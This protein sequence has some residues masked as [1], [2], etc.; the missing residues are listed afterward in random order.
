MFPRLANETN[1]AG[2]MEL[3]LASLVHHSDYFLDNLPINHPL[4][5]AAGNITRDLL[6]DEIRA[7]L[8]DMGLQ[9]SQPD[10]ST[11]AAP[12]PTRVCY[13]WGDRFHKLPR[14]F[15][16]PSI[17]PLGAWQLWW[18]GDGRRD[19]PPYRSISSTDPDTP[20]KKATLLEWSI[21]MRHIINGIEAEMSSP[22]PPI[23]DL[24]H[25]IELFN[26]GYKTLNLKPSK[27]KRRT[28]QI[29]LTT[30][31]RLI[32]EAENATRT[33]PYKPRK[34]PK[35]AC[36]VAPRVCATEQADSAPPSSQEPAI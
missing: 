23:R 14:D 34:R 32:R 25:A 31:L 6:R 16:F 1:L 9:S 15:D 22:L 13:T 4:G 10:S 24:A 29:K 33:F 36:S 26:M 19:Y 21:L 8:Q 18:F 2:I 11:Q 28:T 5:K 20:K 12:R 35:A 30:V 7:L 3:C 27:R 17:D